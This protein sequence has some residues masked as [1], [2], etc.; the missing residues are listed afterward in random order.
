[1][2]TEFWRYINFFITLHYIMMD[3]DDDDDDDDCS[4]SDVTV[5]VG[6]A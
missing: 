3:D 4:G 1:M 6:H 5:T 2:K